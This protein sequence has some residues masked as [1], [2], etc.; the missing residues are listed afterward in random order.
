MFD[1]AQPAT[2][3]GGGK[4]ANSS[5]PAPPQ[6]SLPKGGSIRGLGE[7]FATNPVTG[8]GTFSL[9]IYSSPGRSGFSPQLAMAYDSGGGNGPWGF[10]WK[11]AL[12]SITRKTDKGLPQYNDAQNSDIFL[13]AGAEDLM[14]ALLNSKGTWNFDGTTRPLFGKQYHVQRYRPRVEGLFARIE[15]WTNLADAT[16]MFWRSISKDNVTTWYGLDA[17]SRIADPI[18][19][20]RIFEWLISQSYDA[21]GNVISYVYKAENSEGVDLTQASERNRNDASRSAQRYI[22]NIFYGNRTPYFLNLTG[23]AATALPTD[24]CFELVFDY[25]EHDAAAPAPEEVQPWSCRLD[26]FSTYRPTFDVRTYRF[27]RRVLMFHNF[28]NEQNVGAD[29]LVRS[30]DFVHVSTRPADPSQPF[31]SYLLSAT[32]T[33]YTRSNSGGYL[34][35]AL[36]PVEF[37]YTEAILDETVRDVDPDSLANLPSGIDGSLYRWVDLDGEGFCGVL[38]EQAGNWFYKANLSPV[39]VQRVG[40]ETLTLPRFAPVAVVERLPTLAA[41][42]GEQQQ[43]MSL[44]GDGYVSLVQFDGPTPDISSGL[45]MPTGNPS[46]RSGRSRRSTGRIRT[47]GLSI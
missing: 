6:L 2:D 3:A 36:P 34:S 42:S 22:K 14:P 38:T 16:D 18:N 12:P 29:C 1:R 33:G 27:C 15:R 10:G 43:L 28:S 32:Q 21:K 17:T 9:P 8:T 41:L 5:G 31:Y 35:N 24:W 13:L 11:V 4:A 23:K 47:C 20:S 26:P 30:T 19:S 40:S 37:T 7:K 46:C 44:S 39:N 45:R 25:G